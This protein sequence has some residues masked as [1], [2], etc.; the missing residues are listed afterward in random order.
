MWED[1]IELH[2]NRPTL[3]LN[4]Q[5]L[6]YHP[7]HLSELFLK[8]Q[9]SQSPIWTVIP[10]FIAL[11]IPLIWNIITT[12]TFIHKLYYKFFSIIPKHRYFNSENFFISLF[13]LRATD[14]WKTISP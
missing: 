5:C 14:Y 13:I 2:K 10:V 9:A 3:T 1:S 4:Q 6:F 12:I 11:Y 8:I 7:E